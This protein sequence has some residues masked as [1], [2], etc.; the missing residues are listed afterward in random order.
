MIS[1]EKLHPGFAARCH[2]LKAGESAYSGHP[3]IPYDIHFYRDGWYALWK[4]P[5][6]G[7]IGRHLRMRGELTAFLRGKPLTGVMMG[8][9]RLRKT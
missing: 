6:N 4:N 7:Q 2:A 5:P 8:A 3:S 9:R 1:V